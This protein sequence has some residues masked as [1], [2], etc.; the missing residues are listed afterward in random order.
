MSLPW[1]KLPTEL[2]DSYHFNNLPDLTRLRFFQLLMLAGKGNAGGYLVEEGQPLSLEGIAWRLRAGAG[3]FEASLDDLSAAGLAA[4]DPDRKAWFL[5]SMCASEPSPETGVREYWRNNKRRQRKDRSSPGS[6][7]SP[8]EDQTE[9]GEFETPQNFRDIPFL[10]VEDSEG[11]EKRRRESRTE[12]KRGEEGKRKPSTSILSRTVRFPVR[13]RS[14]RASEA[15]TGPEPPRARYPSPY[16]AS[17]PPAPPG[18]FP[19]LDR[20]E[21]MLCGHFKPPGHCS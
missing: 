21:Q 11:V 13:S 19:A 6:T 10:Y 3:K 12:E 1:V 4:Y 17:R 16:P 5:P 9:P 20:L 7:S 15:L 18:R 2:L 14:R 8:E